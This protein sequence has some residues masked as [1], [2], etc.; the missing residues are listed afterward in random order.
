MNTKTKILTNTLLSTIIVASSICFINEYNKPDTQTKKKTETEET[1]LT[2][3]DKKNSATNFFSLNNQEYLEKINYS[4]NLFSSILE[5]YNLRTISSKK[6][7]IDYTAYETSLTLERL[8]IPNGYKQITIN[9]D[10]NENIKLYISITNTLQK[11][12]WNQ[13]LNISISSNTKP[14]EFNNSNFPEV[15]ELLENF[16]KNIN[17]QSISKDINNVLFNNSNNIVNENY[18]IIKDNKNNSTFVQISI[19]SEHGIIN[20]D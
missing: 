5:K 15:F 10:T 4:S 17:I 11:K 19:Y 14:L 8:D 13:V 12:E 7:D 3:S 16:G 6:E 20:E 2:T 9:P 1:I 18:S